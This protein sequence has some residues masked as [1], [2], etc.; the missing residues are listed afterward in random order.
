MPKLVISGDFSDI[1]ES[2]SNSFW[3]MLLL[4]EQNRR[5]HLV[6]GR[7]QKS[8]LSLVILP[9]LF[10]R[11]LLTWRPFENSNSQDICQGVSPAV[12]RM[13]HT[14]SQSAWLCFSS[15]LVRIASEIPLRGSLLCVIS[16]SRSLLCQLLVDIRWR[17]LCSSFIAS[18]IISKNLS[19]KYGGRFT[20]PG[21]SSFSTKQ[22]KSVFK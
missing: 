22:R 1:E 2:S 4:K 9:S 18:A 6:S 21:T 15:W 20:P 13:H 11:S 16:L 17:W 19:E 8:H 5:W 3:P 14:L 7:Q 10:S 12:L